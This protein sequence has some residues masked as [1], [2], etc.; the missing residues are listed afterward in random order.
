MGLA[1]GDKVKVRFSKFYIQSFDSQRNFFG[2]V[3]AYSDRIKT[4]MGQS[5]EVYMSGSPGLVMN[6]WYLADEWINNFEWTVI[7][8]CSFNLG[9]YVY[10]DEITREI[11]MAS[12]VYILCQSNDGR[13]MLGFSNHFKYEV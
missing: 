4:A 2:I 8:M 9:E 1:V 13:L 11:L 6:K 10:R 7:F 3:P 5:L 12:D